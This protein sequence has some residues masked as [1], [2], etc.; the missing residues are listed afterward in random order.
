MNLIHIISEIGR[1]DPEFYDRISPRRKLIAGLSRKVAFA[2][3]PFALGSLFS[4]AYGQTNDIIVSTLNF[5]L[6]LEYMEVEYYTQGLA[7]AAGSQL[8]ATER[9]D[10]QLLLTNE[11]GHV[12][13]I[14][15]TIIALGGLPDGPPQFD[16]TGGNGNFN[17]P[18][19][20]WNADADNFLALAQAF[21]QTGQRAYKG[22]AANLMSN[23]EVLEAALRIHSVEARHEAKLR[24]MRFAR[25]VA[26]KPWVTLNQSGIAQPEAQGPYAGEEVTVQ[27]GKN[28][29]GLILPG[30]IT[31]SQNAASEAFDEPLTM[32]EV[33]AITDRFVVG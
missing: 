29:S 21:E 10:V 2:A 17:G 3:V 4:K 14:K 31:I 6:K 24:I 26:V 8:S 22:S 28:F 18:F 25:G 23:N 19:T 12:N 32:D 27:A 7:S 9:S 11:T 13:F 15:N 33:L 5:A 20:G 16:F 30:A 1:Q